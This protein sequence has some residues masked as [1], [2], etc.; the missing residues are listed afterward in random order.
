MGGP[1]LSSEDTCPSPGTLGILDGEVDGGGGEL[2]DTMIGYWSTAPLVWTSSAPGFAPSL[3][4][5][6]NSR[7]RDCGSSS[8]QGAGGHWTR[9]L[10]EA[11]EEVIVDYEFATGKCGVSLFG[12]LTW[13]DD[14]SWNSSRSMAHSI[15]SRTGKVKG[16]QSKGNK[17][18]I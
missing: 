13:C 7:E 8:T 2:A 11:R 6:C 16:E 14:V 4:R 18:H 17:A 1:V 10:R 9:T 15:D 3:E 12:K 5:P